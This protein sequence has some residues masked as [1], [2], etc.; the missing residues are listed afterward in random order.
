MVRQQKPNRLIALVRGNYIIVF[1]LAAMAVIASVSPVFLGAAN[2]LGILNQIAIYG[3]VA[4]AMTFAVI[5]GEFDL[6]VATTFPMSGVLFIMFVDRLGVVPAGLVAL[7]YGLVIGSL[8]GVLVAV[9]KLNSFIVTLGTMLLSNG[10]GMTMTRGNTLQSAHAG[11]AAFSDWRLGTLTSFFFIFLALGILS[12]AVLRWTRFGRNLYATG[13][14]QDVA[15][16]SGINTRFYKFIIFVILGLA[17]SL[18]GVLLAVRL[19]AHAADYGKDLAMYTVSVVVIGGAS[20]A[21]GKGSIVKTFFGL[22]FMGII[23]NGFNLV[24]VQ[25]YIQAG[26]KGLILILVVLL[27]HFS[28]RKRAYE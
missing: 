12:Q 8:N 13:G 10:I 28:P 20:L 2:L 5:C 19:S 22:L 27:D 21:G 25:S 11:I 6:S 23:F 18:A 7:A 3:I 1:I 9:L 17:A 26:L 14:N 16:L 15:R 4:F 24:H